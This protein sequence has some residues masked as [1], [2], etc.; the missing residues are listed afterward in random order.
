MGVSNM[1]QG[2]S[3]AQEETRPEKIEED[4]RTRIYE[5]LTELGFATAEQKRGLVEHLR[6]EC[7]RLYDLIVY[8]KL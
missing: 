4:L 2:V 8:S 1:E 6:A 7:G 5:A 3:L